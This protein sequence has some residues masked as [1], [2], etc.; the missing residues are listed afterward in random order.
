MNARKNEL[1][2]TWSFSTTEWQ[3]FV[4]IEKRIKEKTISI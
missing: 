2:D 3:A 1:L 4:S